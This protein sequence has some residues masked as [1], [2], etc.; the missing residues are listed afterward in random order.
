M[1]QSVMM[2]SR[3]SLCCPVQCVC[4]NLWPVS[5][6]PIGSTPSAA[7]VQQRQAALARRGVQFVLKLLP[8]HPY[9]LCCPAAECTAQRERGGWV[10]T[11]VDHLARR[12]LACGVQPVSR[13][14]NIFMACTLGLH[15]LS[16][17]APGCRKL[18]FVGL[19][20]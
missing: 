3:W 13:I 11:T 15:M 17:V 4:G 9:I 12:F 7:M 19:P 14:C 1:R 5:I 18:V 8:A 16:M 20:V 2:V 6:R 10:G